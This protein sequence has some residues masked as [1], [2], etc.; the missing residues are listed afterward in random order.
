MVLITWSICNDSNREINKRRLEIK[1]ASLF[2]IEIWI[3]IG[4]VEIVIHFLA[5]FCFWIKCK[6][7]E[8]NVLS[9]LS[10]PSTSLTNRKSEM[11]LIAGLSCI[12]LRHLIFPSERWQRAPG[13]QTLC[14]GEIPFVKETKYSQ[15]KFFFLHSIGFVT[16]CGI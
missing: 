10:W 5:L 14:L 3:S 2:G 9:F 11:F 6:S 15:Q 8:K 12:Y 1:H 13:I 4:A 7:H 16:D